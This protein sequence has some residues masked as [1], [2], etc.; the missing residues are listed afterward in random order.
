MIAQC[1][2]ENSLERDMRLDL[3]KNPGIHLRNFNKCKGFLPGLR[4]ILDSFM[5]LIYLELM[6][7]SEVGRNKKSMIDRISKSHG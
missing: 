5:L 6:W 1:C 2:I 3:R 7:D 4:K